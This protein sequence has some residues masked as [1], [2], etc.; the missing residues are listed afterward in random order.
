MKRVLITGCDSG[1]G[2]E[3]ALQYATA[4]WEVW[5]TYYDVAN[6]PTDGLDTAAV[7]HC[8]LDVTRPD[9]FTRLK[10]QLGSAPL[11]ILISNAGIGLERGKLG[12]IDYSYAERMY[13][14]NCLGALRLIETFADNVAVSEQR[15]FVAI[16]SRMGSIGLNFT[17]GH[18]GYRAS[19]AALNAVL[20]SLTIDL[21]S[22]NICVVA[23]HPGPAA[24][25]SAPDAP[26]SVSESVGSM[27]RLIERL[28]MHE[29]GQF[30]RYDGVPLPW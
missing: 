19:K 27:R 24:V 20:R 3:F 14:T 13:E 2:R 9:Q 15:R 22:H 12:A 4:G 7:H 8:Q 30:Y 25:P 11:D 23:L 28:S 1:L 6:R 29:T 5:A 16:S 18:Y 10:Q 26:L 21:R 17:G